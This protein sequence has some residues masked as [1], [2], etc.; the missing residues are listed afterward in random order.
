MVGSCYAVCHIMLSSEYCDLWRMSCDMWYA[1]SSEKRDILV[2]FEAC[3]ASCEGD[4]AFV[5]HEYS[6]RV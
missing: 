2:V 4:C 5:P 1:E 6:L 3:I